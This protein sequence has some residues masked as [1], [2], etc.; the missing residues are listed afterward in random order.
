MV[1]TL[2]WGEYTVAKYSEQARDEIA[3]GLRSGAL[4]GVNLARYLGHTGQV[5]DSLV[6]LPNVKVLTFQDLPDVALDSLDRF[7]E[8]EEV[9][10]D[11]TKRTLDLARMPALRT[12]SANWH[13]KL[14]L[15]EETSRVT[16]LHI[17][18]FRPHVRDLTQ[19]P[20]FPHLSVLE[21]IQSNIGSL[22][23][24]KSFPNLRKLQLHQLD[25]LEH[26]T[27]LDLRHLLV[28]IA[29]GCRKMADHENLG[30]CEMLQ[31]LKLH[32]CGTIKSLDFVKHLANL[33]S[34]RFLDTPVADGDYSPLHRL[35][36]VYFTASR[37]FKAKPSEFRQSPTMW[38]TSIQ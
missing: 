32:R 28:F 6:G 16:S 38:R 12:I 34:F 27:K 31:E 15:N 1:D 25:R 22:H 24:I 23:G 20:R 5:L 8:L 29:D 4:S 19:A 21:L 11:E 2:D 36:D 18:K 35:E 14:F 26:L 7:P 10:F 17:W 30:S 9:A 33:K 37:K 3:D 13:P